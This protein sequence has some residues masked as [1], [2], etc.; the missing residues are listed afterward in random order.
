[1]S[2]YVRKRTFW[3]VRPTKTQST[4][5]VRA[6]WPEY[7]LSAWKSFAPL[8][9]KYASSI[10]SNQTAN[11]LGENARRYVFWHCDSYAHST[12]KTPLCYLRT[13]KDQIRLRIC[14]VWSGLSLPLSESPHTA[15][16]INGQRK[17]WWDCA[18][19]HRGWAVVG[20]I[21]QKSPF[22]ASYTVSPWRASL[23]KSN[24]TGTRYSFKNALLS[25]HF[26]PFYRSTTHNLIYL[27]WKITDWFSVKYG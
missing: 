15:E 9:I 22:L 26:F 10:N 2:G 25:Y 18:D 7:S 13:T 6:V 21:W 3:H 24:L 27:Q 5:F 14:A 4:L 16:Y 1:M 11:A 20:R 8:A 12:R 17:P 23:I 19:M